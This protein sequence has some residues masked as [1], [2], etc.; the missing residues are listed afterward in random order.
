[1]LIRKDP[2]MC[3]EYFQHKNNAFMKCASKADSIFE[4]D[5]IIDFFDRVEFQQRGSPHV[6]KML[7][8]KNAPKIDPDN[9]LES[10]EKSY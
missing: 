8:L 5:S 3:A 7:W 9:K 6:H 10:E 1:M 4:A 2:V